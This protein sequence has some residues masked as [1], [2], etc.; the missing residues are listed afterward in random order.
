MKEAIKH[1]VKYMVLGIIAIALVLAV[2]TLFLAMPSILEWL[3]GYIGTT[4]TWVVFIFI[5]IAVIFYCTAE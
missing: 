3:S 2:F 1:T 4:M 5:I